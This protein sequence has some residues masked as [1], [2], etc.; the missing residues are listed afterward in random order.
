MNRKQIQT[1]IDNNQTVAPDQRTTVV[2]R[3]IKNPAWIPV[4]IESHGPHQT[5]VTVRRVDFDET[6]RAQVADHEASY[7]PRDLIEHDTLSTLTANRRAMIDSLNMTASVIQSSRWAVEPTEL[8]DRVAEHLNRYGSQ[9]I[10]KTDT[11]IRD[12]VLRLHLAQTAETV[13]ADRLD[14]NSPQTQTP[15]VWWTPTGNF[16]VSL[17]L[18]TSHLVALLTYL[19]VVGES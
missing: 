4:S 16:S 15:H 11:E 13:I 9:F 8:A 10:H 19:T 18:D 7:T 3:F 1:I 6:G 14:L 17:M 5:V 2:G 12:Y